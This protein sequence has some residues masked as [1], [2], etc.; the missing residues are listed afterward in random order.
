MILKGPNYFQFLPHF[1]V[2]VL[3]D[4]SVGHEYQSMYFSVMEM[5]L[6]AILPNYI[7]ELFSCQGMCDI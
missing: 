7:K 1:Q 6:C 4:F 5:N 3:E 2:L